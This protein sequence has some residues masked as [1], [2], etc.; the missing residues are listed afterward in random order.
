M[1]KEMSDTPLK[2]NKPNFVKSESD[3]QNNQNNIPPPQF[4]PPGVMLPPGMM[5]P[6]FPFPHGVRPPKPKR[7]STKSTQTKTKLPG[8]R[9]LTRGRGE[10]RTPSPERVVDPNAVV[11]PN[12]TNEQ[13]RSRFFF[14]FLKHSVFLVC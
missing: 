9:V 7:P 8:D 11:D 13:S 5:A 6:P 1:K 3:F 10:S 14:F 2:N 12:H 4:L